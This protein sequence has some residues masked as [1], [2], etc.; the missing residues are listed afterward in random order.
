MA[1]NTMRRD[2]FD[3]GLWALYTT[4]ATESKLSSHSSWIETLRRRVISVRDGI[5]R[6]RSRSIV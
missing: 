2:D 5:V 3:E 4:L 6:I 1:G